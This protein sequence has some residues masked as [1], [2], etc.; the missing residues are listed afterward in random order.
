[1]GSW[2]EHLFALGHDAW[3]GRWELWQLAAAAIG[4]VV[5]LRASGRHTLAPYAFG[6]V[7]ATALA[8]LVGGGAA[9]A[10]WA[11]AR[12]GPPPEVEIAGTGA[13]LGLALGFTWAARRRGLTPGRALDALAP[14]VGPVLAVAR[15]GCFFAGCDFGAP[16]H[17]PWA[18]RYP[19]GTAAFAHQRAQ[20]LV[21]LG[22]AWTVPV[23]P[24]QVYELAAGALLAVVGAAPSRGPAGARFL[25]VVVAFAVLRA[26]ADVARGDLARG[27]WGLTSTQWLAVAVLGAAVAYRTRAVGLPS[28]K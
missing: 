28:A 7:S 10:A 27:A 6:L 13:L 1:V 5:L 11:L 22:A 26:C 17:A 23:H 20:G 12:R 18:M 19:T 8:L 21:D 24:A 9:W 15:V 2:L 4:A 16:S 25:R 14:A 3:W